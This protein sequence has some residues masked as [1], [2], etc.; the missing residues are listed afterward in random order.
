[1]SM[2]KIETLDEARK[3]DH[4][5][6]CGHKISAFRRDLEEVKTSV[7]HKRP[8]SGR[9]GAYGGGKE[10]NLGSINFA[11]SYKETEPYKIMEYVVSQQ[12]PIRMVPWSELKRLIDTDQIQGYQQLHHNSLQYH[13]YLHLGYSQEPRPDHPIKGGSMDFKNAD[14]EYQWLSTVSDHPDCNKLNEGE[15]NSLQAQYYH[16]AKGHWLINSIQKEGLWQCIQGHT[17]GGGQGVFTDADGN[18]TT[19]YHTPK[20]SIHPGSVRS[21]VYETMDDPDFPIL[22]TDYINLFPTIK[23]MSLD[24]IISYWRDTVKANTLTAVYTKDGKIEWSPSNVGGLD[25]RQHVYGFHKKVSKLCK[26]KPVNIYLGYDSS[27]SDIFDVAEN[28]IHESIEKCKSGGNSQEFFNDFKVEVKKLDINT[29]P[30]YTRDYANQ[31]TEFTYSRF[32][33]PYLEN[34]EGFSIFIDDDYIWRYSPLSLFYFLDPD[35][36]VACVQYD[37]KE[38]DETKFNG[39]KNVSYPKKLWSS[40]MIFNNGHNDCKTLTPELV[41]RASGEFL[42]QFN[43]TDQ[44]SKIPHDKIATE[45]FDR[46]MLKSHHAVHYTRGGPWI[47]GMDCEHINML[48]I[49]ETYKRKLKV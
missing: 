32:L 1:M 39:E 35:D 21:K 31:S 36:A 10:W 48:E 9:A 43:W 37:F 3:I 27:H 8:W 34:Y 20:I 26:K 38:H 33:I 42:H 12:P 46:T 40:M 24:D 44:I 5:E 15:E 2:V 22:V 6:S 28:S 13:R 16:A 7:G 45:G 14:D 19:L 41:N 18:E 29:I 47:K 4:C 11:N 25:F 23:E 17:A 30:E 49:Y